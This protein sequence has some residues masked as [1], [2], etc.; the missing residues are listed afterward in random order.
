MTV[1]VVAQLSFTEEPRYRRYQARFP[2][3]FAGHNGRVLAADEAPQGAEGRLA[4]SKLAMREFEDEAAS[5]GF[6]DS[7]LYREISIDRDT[8]AK[9]TAVLVRGV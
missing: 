5:R 3:A 8:G 4:V 7:S 2:E 6:L 1:Y 9:T